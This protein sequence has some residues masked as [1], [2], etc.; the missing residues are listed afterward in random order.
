M[1]QLEVDPDVVTMNL[2]IKAAGI[3][4][5]LHIVEELYHQMVTMGPTPTAITFVHLF[6]AY[7]HSERREY[8]QLVQV[9]ATAF[10][11]FLLTRSSAPANISRVASEANRKASMLRIFD[12]CQLPCKDSAALDA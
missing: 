9:L 8:G 6:S 3:S 7:E 11:R 2:L 10:E 1:L 5:Q 4:G 12:I